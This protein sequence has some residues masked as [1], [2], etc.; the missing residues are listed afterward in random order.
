MLSQ[1]ILTY[2][3]LYVNN[4]YVLPLCVFVAPKRKLKLLK[5]ILEKS[6][7]VTAN[8]KVSFCFLEYTVVYT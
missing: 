5:D 3:T 6:L 7:V 8:V 1:C 4:K 2:L